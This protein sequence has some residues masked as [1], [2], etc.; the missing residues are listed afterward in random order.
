[1]AAGAQQVLAQDAR[2]AGAAPAQRLLLTTY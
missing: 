1:M 2:D